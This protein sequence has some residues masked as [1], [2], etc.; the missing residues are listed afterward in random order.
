[1]L[2][3]PLPAFSSS[4]PAYTILLVDDDAEMR[5]Y[6]RRC[7][8]RY[9]GGGHVCHEAADGQEA[10]D[11]LGTHTADLV[12]T[13]VV[14]PRMDGLALCRSLHERAR[15]EGARAVPAR[16]LSVLVI[17]GEQGVEAALPLGAHGA[18]A[19]PF[20]AR[21]LADALDQVLAR[22]PPG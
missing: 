8:R 17:S 1:M 2:P 22:A 14:M 18:L 7:L 11:W 16:P 13:D 6:L 4:P 3:V 20:N 5:G 9:G 21:T 19:K 12:I 15:H 10:L